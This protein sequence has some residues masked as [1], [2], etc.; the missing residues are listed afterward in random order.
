VK[1]PVPIP[2]AVSQIIY[3]DFD[4]NAAASTDNNSGD[5]LRIVFNVDQAVTDVH[6]AVTSNGADITGSTFGSAHIRKIT[7]GVEESTDLSLADAVPKGD[8][9]L[10]IP[11]TQMEG[12]SSRDITITAADLSGNTGS[13]V[14]TLLR[15]SLFPLD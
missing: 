12:Y 11:L 4:F 10:Y 15:R 5:E 2:N 8:Y 13:A 7:G 9:A 6:L 3:V 1:D 14:V